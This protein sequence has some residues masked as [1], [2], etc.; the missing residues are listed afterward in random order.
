[1]R[2]FKRLLFAAAILYFAIAAY[3]HYYGAAAPESRT[4]EG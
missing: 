3:G 1:M 2:T 4:G